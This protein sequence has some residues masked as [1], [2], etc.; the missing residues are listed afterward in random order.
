[1]TVPIINP[2]SFGPRQA[3][4]LEQLM[5]DAKSAVE[6]LFGKTDPKDM[7]A[8]ARAAIENTERIRGIAARLFAPGTEGEQL[9]EALCDAT[10]RRPV[11][12]TQLGV[13]PMQALMY[14]AFREGQ[15]AAIFLLLAWIA[16]GRSEQPPQR[17]GESN[18]NNVR[19]RRRKPAQSDDRPANDGARA[20]GSSG[21]RK[22]AAR[23]T[24]RKSAG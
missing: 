6:D 17:E 8:F 13:D 20:A 7:P 15:G 24:R 23:G 12:I 19:K 14:G 4:P 22:P 2:A 18:A 9:L 10:L 21:R 11:F 1:M 3:Q 5:G 16:E